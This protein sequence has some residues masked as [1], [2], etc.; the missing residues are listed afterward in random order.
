VG[1]KKN[2]QK[3]YMEKE[4]S[5][6]GVVIG[7]FQIDTLHEGHLHLINTVLEN[8]DDV[9]VFMG[10]APVFSMRNALSY[11][12]RELMLK[13]IYGDRIKT[14]PL[15]DTPEDIDWVKNLDNNIK[16]HYGKNT[17]AVIY[18]GAKESCIPTY[19]QYN[20]KF[21]T[22][23]VKTLHNDAFIL[24]ATKYREEIAKTAIDSVDFRKGIIYALYNC[25][26]PTTFRTA[27]V[28]I[29]RFYDGQLQVLLGQKRN[30]MN[31]DL[32]RFPGG[33]VDPMNYT[34]GNQGD[35]TGKHAAAREALEETSLVLNPKNIKIIDEIQVNDWRYF[36]TEHSIMTTIYN[37]H[38]AEDDTQVA[39]GG[40]DLPN[41]Q[42]FNVAE[43]E[44]IVRPLH[45]EILSIFMESDT[46]FR[47]IMMNTNKPIMI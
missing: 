32:W 8:H 34:T 9:I 31:S 39:I 15:R 5:K 14:A 33:F 3:F 43:A 22:Q 7:R 1:Y 30:E 6:V 23:E 18:G 28:I 37:T 26:Y 10:V 46:Y 17:E 25:V 13:G 4:R 12:V 27:D 45:K 29:T 44:E 24:A 16:K 20:G 36:Y 47:L 11:Q 35:K 41:V 40:D 19:V 38:L 21:E 2:L 42:W